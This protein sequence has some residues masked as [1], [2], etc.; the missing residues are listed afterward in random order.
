[1][2]EFYI[3]ERV[4][5]L[6]GAEIGDLARTVG[7]GRVVGYEVDIPTDADGEEDGEDINSRDY[8]VVRVDGSRPFD[9]WVLPREI[10]TLEVKQ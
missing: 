9:Q 2:P 7:R 3:G 1:M 10:D 5:F 8:V 4:R 6:P